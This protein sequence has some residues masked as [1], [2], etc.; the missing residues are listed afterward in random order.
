L[1][2]RPV[3]PIAIRTPEFFRN[4]DPLWFRC[5]SLNGFSLHADVAVVAR[6]RK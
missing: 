3:Y 1:C 6:D 5:A 4:V 2:F